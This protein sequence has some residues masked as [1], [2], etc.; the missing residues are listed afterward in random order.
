MKLVSWLYQLLK[1]NSGT[2]ITWLA[3]LFD[4]FKASNPLIAVLIISVL[5]AIN[6][7]V[8]NCTFGA[9]CDA[10]WFQDIVFWVTTVLIGLQG[11]RTTRYVA[12]KKEEK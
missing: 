10:E 2:V 3:G 11:S 7:F 1:N 12:P 9:F 5:I 4:K 8:T 6:H